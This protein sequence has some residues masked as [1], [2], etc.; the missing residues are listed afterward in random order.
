MPI[1]EEDAAAEAAAAGPVAVASWNWVHATRRLTALENQELQAQVRGCWCGDKKGGEEQ[2]AAAENKELDIVVID[3]IVEYVMAMVNHH[4]DTKKTVRDVY[5]ALV[6]M[7]ELHDTTCPPIMAHQIATVLASFLSSINNNNKV[8]LATTTTTTEEAQERTAAVAA[9]VGVEVTTSGSIVAA[10]PSL[11][12]NKEEKSSAASVAAAIYEE[13]VNN[14]NSNEEKKCDDDENN[15]NKCA[16]DEEANFANVQLRLE[17]GDAAFQ[18]GDYRLAEREYQTAISHI[19]KLNTRM[20]IIRS[21]SSSSSSSH[22]MNTASSSS[23]VSHGGEVAQEE[24][25]KTPSAPTAGSMTTCE[26]ENISNGDKVQEEDQVNEYPLT[27][28][29]DDD[30]ND[31]N[32][33]SCENNNE[34]LLAA[35]MVKWN[36][37]RIARKEWKRASIYARIALLHDES[38]QDAWYQLAKSLYHQ[39]R[40]RAAL[41]AAKK[42]GAQQNNNNH[43]NDGDGGR[44]QRLMAAM[45]DYFFRVVEKNRNLFRRIIDSYR[46][47]SHDVN[48]YYR[49]TTTNSSSS[50]SATEGGDEEKEGNRSNNNKTSCVHSLYGLKAQRQQQFIDNAEESDH[51]VDDK[52]LLPLKHFRAYLRMGRGV[53]PDS[54]MPEK[55]KIS[56]QALMA[57]ATADDWANIGVTITPQEIQEHYNDANVN[58]NSGGDD[59]VLQ[60]LRSFAVSIAGQIHGE[61]HKDIMDYLSEDDDEE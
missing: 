36:E 51:D 18:Y 37:V 49:T 4:H 57:M 8:T 23:D 24:E 38:N 15:N 30:E 5:D 61:G 58:N 46:L 39:K 28:H 43:G 22:V 14:D 47:W 16:V 40:L 29:D 1:Q 44:G 27:A 3:G 54:L 17:N 9:D 25:D 34:K 31:N 59:S 55:N 35:A 60:S 6:E 19:K 10:T 20:T 13:D 41:E 52:P 21:S 11:D 56:Y 53:L 7:E 2:L 32:N 42:M 26:G 50:S 45:R 33:N 48:E 12:S